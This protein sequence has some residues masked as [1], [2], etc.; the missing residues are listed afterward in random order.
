MF[1]ISSLLWIF[2]GLLCLAGCS[3]YLSKQLDQQF[4]V[5]SPLNRI[6]LPNNSFAV[7]P[8]DSPNYYTD[9]APVLE[10]RCVV[11]HACYDAPCQLKLESL[12]GLERGANSQKVYNG[13][14]LLA[15]NLT[16]LFEDA[17]STQAWRDKGFFPVLNERQQ[18]PEAHKASVFYRMLALKQQHPLP[19]YGPLPDSFDFSLDRSQS[20]TTA[21]EFD[22]YAE[23]FP[24]GGMPYG[25]PGIPAH[26]Q[27]DLMNWAANGAPVIPR[28]QPLSQAHADAIKQW[29]AFFNRDD[30]KGRLVARYM[31]EHLYLANLHFGQE[32]DRFFQLIR[33][34][35]A[36]GEVPDRIA[37]R[38]PFDDPGVDRVYYRLIPNPEAIVA[39]SHMPYRLDAARMQ[40]W[41]A[42][43]YQTDYRVTQWP[44]YEPSIAANPFKAFQALPAKSRY[45]FMLE[46]AQYTI[47][48]FIKGPV[49][50]GQT[51][52]NVI[53][54]QF[55]V[56]FLDPEYPDLDD[57]GDVL[58]EH[59]DNLAL[60]AERDSTA[61]IT[62]WLTYS[63]KQLA[64]LKAQEQYINEHLKAYKGPSLEMIWQGDGVNDNAAL[65]VLRHFDSATVAK[66][67][68]G[69]PPKTAWVISYSLLERIHY[70]LV[71][72]FDVY[73]NIGHQLLTR[74]YMDFL[75]ME[76]EQNFLHF[77]PHDAAQ[78]ELAFW[79]RD[80]HEEV[81]KFFRQTQMA[82]GLKTQIRYTT[83]N[84]KAELY[85]KLSD[86]LRGVK[87]VSHNINGNLH[88]SEHTRAQLNR[89]E[90]LSGASLQW[91]PE[92][93][94]LYVN[95][96]SPYRPVLITLFRNSAHL[97]IN[98]L[99]LEKLNRVPAE[100]TL[101]VAAGV[102]TYYPN[103]LY[104][105]NPDSLN[106][107]IDGIP[108]LT[109]KADYLQLKQA[110]G[111]TRNAPAFW[112]VSD[113]IHALFHTQQPENFGWL[114]YN[115]LENP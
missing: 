30:L 6:I 100:D 5:E 60:P 56:F 85:S 59:S 47:M 94:L 49:C 68:V 14:R 24:L 101:S 90:S 10:K 95:Q 65:T 41:Q 46:E 55:W 64:H 106:A 80:A 3:L 79:Y 40:R 77:L 66:G 67:L 4:G 13:T 25:L 83:D 82:D 74:T 48:G 39:K 70:L 107:F 86:W 103:A 113:R 34:R 19:T 28:D 45:R 43:F 61:G 92:T 97:N 53:N 8:T 112:A 108:Q 69:E 11:C 16:R 20:C 115:R 71:A 75:R 36:P 22:R 54:D 2:T 12:A 109:S 9:V 105:L 33:S 87:N 99:L 18:T 57:I 21:A 93:S 31:Y 98:S 102:L 72:G 81:A 15:A 17:D 32:P 50:R 114:D 62:G 37:T 35:T 52:L 26:E 42:L 51:A 63:K 1:R 44:G 29:E 7:T 23:R 58:A 110:Y 27:Q 76:G 38:R 91:L 111:V 96:A 88:L 73:G 104:E 84:P 78:K 89:L